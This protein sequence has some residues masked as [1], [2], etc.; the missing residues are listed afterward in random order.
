MAE[1][2]TTFLTALW[3]PET[4][5]GTVPADANFKA[6]RAV[7]VEDVR[8]VIDAGIERML[9]QKISSVSWVGRESSEL[10][11]RSQPV[12]G[13]LAHLF[14][15]LLKNVTPQAITEGA[16]TVG[17]KWDFTPALD[18]EETP[19]TFTVALQPYI[20]SGGAKR[21]NIP[22]VL[23]NTLTVRIP[24]QGRP[25]LT[26]SAIGRAMQLNQSV[27]SSP[28]SVEA[29][30]MLAKHASVY[31]DSTASG[32]GT[33]KMTR[34]LE[35]ELTFENRWNPLY[36]LDASQSSFAVHI[37]QPVVARLR[38]LMEADA[39]GV[40]GL[41]Q[42]RSNTT[43]FIRLDVVG[44]LLPSAST[45]TY[46]LR[47]DMAG[48]VQSVGTFRDQDGVFAVEYTFEAIYSTAFSPAKALTVTVQNNVQA[49]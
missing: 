3:A 45:N 2:T 13:Q 38:L 36:V 7:S 20:D 8:P 15:S 33:T 39:Q 26:A 18:T 22:Y 16:T 47:V 40:A 27:I 12:Y 9:G 41:D 37:E 1:S 6:L 4:T 5:P 17:Y 34:V 23:V 21:I 48:A 29:V 19:K 30:P 10:S 43:K 14:C 42:A 32:I 31:I 28:P 44:P 11:I 25:E 35:A 49:L 24:A 46:L